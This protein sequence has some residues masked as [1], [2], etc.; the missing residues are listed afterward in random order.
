MIR[1]NINLSEPYAPTAIKDILLN[2]ISEK[3]YHETIN[4]LKKTKHFIKN[5]SFYDYGEMQDGY[6]KNR[7]YV[8]PSEMS[9]VL[10]AIDEL[11][12]MWKGEQTWRL[13]YS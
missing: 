6:R 12:T 11:I 10:E 13:H 1:Y 4:F 7:M 9:E 5:H 3:E 8:K 2:E